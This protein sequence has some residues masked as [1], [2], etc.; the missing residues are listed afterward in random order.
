M[1]E[2]I[3]VFEIVLRV[4]AIGY[5]IYFFETGATDRYKRPQL[6]AWLLIHFVSC[7]FCFL[8]L[9]SLLKSDVTDYKT[10]FRLKVGLHLFSFF[11]YVGFLFAFHFKYILSCWIPFFGTDYWWVYLCIDVALGGGY[12]LFYGQLCF[13]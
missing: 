3:S 7:I 5:F 2:C 11:V 6:Y 13:R 8:T 1:T 12:L 10:Y 4:A 9:S